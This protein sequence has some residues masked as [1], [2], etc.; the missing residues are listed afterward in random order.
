MTVPRISVLDAEHRA[1]KAKMTPFGGWEMPL[2]YDGVLDEHRSCRDDVVVFDV[3]HLGSVVVRGRGSLEGL[4]G[5]LTND[6]R[7]VEP[8]RAQY[9]HLLDEDD[10]H[11]VDDIIVWWLDDDDF[12]VIP[13]AANTAR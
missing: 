13:N 9:T 4:Q 12:L 7:K 3:S 8:G 6:L 10:A 11:V 1:L 2:Q 5:L